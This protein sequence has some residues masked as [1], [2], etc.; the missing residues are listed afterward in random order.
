MPE[1]SIQPQ[2]QFYQLRNG[3]FNLVVTLFQ[4]EEKVRGRTWAKE[5]VS[6]YLHS[7]AH[8]IQTI[9]NATD[10]EKEDNA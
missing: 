3:V 4:E 7:L 6:S 9:D 1:E 10:Q 5:D 2:D 8:E